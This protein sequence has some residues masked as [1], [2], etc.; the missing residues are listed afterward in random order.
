MTSSGR[1]QAYR[2]T[3]GAAQALLFVGLPFVRLGGESALRFDVPS[4]TLHVLGA[5]FAM[6]Q[7]FVVLPATMFLVFAF[8]LVTVALGRVWCGWSCPQTILGDLTRLVQPE[9]RRRQRRWRR[10][11]GFALV[12]LVSAVASAATLWY[13]VTPWEFLSRLAAG[14]LGPVLGWSWAVLGVTLFLDLAFLR[15]RFCA[16][17][18]PYAKVQGVLF[19]RSTLVVAYDERREDDCVDCGACV[20]VCPTGIDIR[21]GL[22]MECIACAECVD[23]CTPIMLKLGRP[24]NLV[25]YFFGE[26]GTVRRLL[27][28]A[29][30]V[31]A[32]ATTLSLGATVAAAVQAGR[33]TLDLVAVP[34]SDFAP[35]LAPDGRALNAYQ[36]SLENHARAPVTVRL[37]AAAPGL[38]LQLRPAEV[39]LSAGEHRRLRVVAEARGPPGRRLA[40][41][42]AE[43]A[44]QVTPPP[45]L[46][47]TVLV[48]V[49]EAP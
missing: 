25:G 21:D 3:A 35:R 20:R 22:Q 46:A 33:A 19:D 4:L 42:T 15:A 8:L 47:T 6:N 48:V 26:P 36:V 24:T 13:F 9:A 2:R 10:P 40:T 34:A 5:S 29:T 23:A 18:C 49:P 14:R 45:R 32:A 12:G 31:L 43:A 44:G 11:A 1:I 27:R 28:P 17:A 41:L 38:E 39:A 7:F 37:A 16:T 30:L